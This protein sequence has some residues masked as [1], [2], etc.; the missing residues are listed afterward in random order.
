MKQSIFMALALLLC[1]LLIGG[2][3]AEDTQKLPE[4]ELILQ[5]L[6][7]DAYIETYRY[8]QEGNTIR[9]GDKSDYGKALQTLLSQAGYTITIDGSFGAKSVGVLNTVQEA[10]GLKTTNAVN[11][12]CFR[13]LAT[14]L[15]C[16]RFPD[17]AEAV[18][19]ELNSDEMWHYA[20]CGRMKEGR[21]WLAQKCFEKSGSKI[22]A[23][24]AK[25]CAQP[26]PV[27]KEL[28][29]RSSTEPNRCSVFLREQKDSGIAMLKILD[30]TG[31]TVSLM[32]LTR[33]GKVTCDLPEGTYMMQVAHGTAW[34]GAADAFGEEGMYA[35]ILVNGSEKIEL[36]MGRE[37]S[38]YVN[39][40]DADE[41]AV[42]LTLEPITWKDFIQ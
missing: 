39:P 23:K 36:V 25:K 21:Y 38:L 3:A 16:I 32:I 33:K 7:E 10:L 17:K 2:A 22:S 18:A 30:E 13:S 12:D 9:K 19:G 28:F 14:Y 11:A 37:Y 6:G 29:H 24:A 8:L 41:N 27:S 35:R 20:G 42:D 15:W 26:S 1:L 4:M 31:N 40:K 5:E 34:F